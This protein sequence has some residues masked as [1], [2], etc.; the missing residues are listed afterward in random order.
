MEKKLRK[1]MDFQRF[2]GNQRL[3]AIIADVENR[4]EQSLDDD[5]LAFV[6]AAGEP[7]P[8]VPEEETP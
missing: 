5:A 4:Y 7:T 6:S 2:A 3:S 8:A 1:I